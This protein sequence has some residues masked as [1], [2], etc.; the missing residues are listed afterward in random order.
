MAPDPNARFRLTVI[1]WLALI[2]LLISK[3]AFTQ[4]VNGGFGGTGVFPVSCSNN[5]QRWFGAEIDI[6]SS[7]NRLVR[8]Y[9]TGAS[10]GPYN[11]GL[12]IYNPPTV[13][14]GPRADDLDGVAIRRV[15]S[16]LYLVTIGPFTGSSGPHANWCMGTFGIGTGAQF[17]W[18]AYVADSSGNLLNNGNPYTFRGSYNTHGDN[19]DVLEWYASPAAGVDPLA[20]LPNQLQPDNDNGSGDSTYIFRVQYANGRTS[21]LNL[22]PRWGWTYGTLGGDDRT[23]LIV[24]DRLPKAAPTDADAGATRRIT[25]HGLI[26]GDYPWLYGRTDDAWIEQVGDYTAEKPRVGVLDDYHLRTGAEVL[27]F[28][29][30]N[31]QRPHFMLREDPED[32][33]FRDTY[34]VRY[35]YVIQP[36]DFMNFLDNLFQF[37]YDPPGPDEQDTVTTSIYGTPVSNGYVSL[38][39]G[40]HTYEFAATDDFFPPRGVAY[41][42]I[43]WPGNQTRVEYW[44]PYPET[45]YWARVYGTG[46]IS[47]EREPRYTRVIRPFGYPY[48]S[49]DPDQYPNVNP[50]LSGFPY[51]NPADR[52]GAPYMFPEGGIAP[53]YRFMRTYQRVGGEPR[54]VPNIMYELFNDSSKQYELYPVISPF[55]SVAPQGGP[56]GPAFGADPSRP[57]QPTH[58]TNDD[59]IR[60]NY[61][62]IFEQNPNDSYTDFRGGKWTRS[63]TYTFLVNY[64]RRPSRSPTFIRC[65]IRKNLRGSAPGNWVGFTMNQ[66][67][68]SDT[69]YSNGAV[70]Y[71]QVSADQLPGGGGPGDYNYYF[72]ASDGS[73]T[74]I[75]PN[76][77]PA[78]TD[79][80]TRSTHLEYDPLLPA[81]NR[82]VDAGVSVSSAGDNDYYWFRVNDPPVLSDA[83]VLP[84]SDR[85]GSNFVYYVT[86]TDRDGE[87]LNPAAR[88]DEPFEATIHIDLF[89]DPQGTNEVAGISTGSLTYTTE[90]GAGYPAGTLVDANRPFYIR[91]E[92]AA[93]PA[94]RGLTYR[95]TSNDTTTIHATPV[96]PATGL[97]AD[98][99]NVGDTFEI[100]QWFDATMERVTPSD[101]DATDGIRYIL[102]TA[103]LI[104][105][106]PGLH[107]YYFTFRDDWGDWLYPD[108]PNVSVEGERVRYPGSSEFE[109]PEVLGNTAPVLTNYRFTPD[110]PGAG[111]DGT[112]ATGFQFYVTYRDA[113][114]DPPSV[115][116]LGID[117]TQDTPDL[118]LNMMPSDPNDTV[119]TDGVVYETNPVRLTAGK[120]VFRAQTSDGELTYPPRATPSD[121]LLFVGPPDVNGTP[122][123]SAAGPLVAQNTAPVLEFETH[124]A[125]PAATSPG[126]EPDAGTEQDTYTY[127]IIYK[128]ADVFAGVQGNPPLWVRVY[129]DGV[130]QDMTQV[131][132]TD[133]D[134]TD[135]AL[136]E[137]KV[138]GLVAGTAHSYYFRASDGLDTARRPNFPNKY[139]GPRVDQPPGGA[140]SLVVADVPND[141]GGAIQGSFNPSND[142]GGGADDVTEYRVY[143]DTNQNMIN[144][145]LAVTVP[146]AGLGAYSFVHDTAPKATDLWYVVRAY[147]GTNESVNSNVA[148]PVRATDNIPPQAPT[149][150]TVN[151]PGAGSR[152]DLTWTKSGDDPPAGAADV[153]EYRIYRAQQSGGYGAALASVPAGTTTYQDTTATDGVDFFYLI[154]AWDGENLSANSNEVGPVQSTDNSPPVLSDF[155][156]AP[157]ARNVP[158]DTNISF[159]AT[160]T[161]AGVNAAT[162]KFEVTVGGVPVTGTISQAPVPNGFRFTLDPENDF[163]ELDVVSVNIEVSDLAVPVPRT[164]RKSY[165][166]IIAAPPTYTI[167]GTITE[168]DAQ[169]GTK[170]VQGVVV[171][172]GAL[173]GT[174]DANGVYTITGLVNG[175]YEVVP[176]RKGKAF[177][178]ASRNVTVADA[179]VPGVDF[180]AVSGYNI[181]GHVRGPNGPMA[182]VRVSNGLKDAVTN[183]RG[184]YKIPNSPAG[185]YVVRAALPGFVF[186][187]TEQVVVLPGS[188]P[189]GSAVNIDFVGSVETFTISGTVSTAD[190]GVLAGARVTAEDATAAII[191]SG[192]TDTN[193]A[194][195]LR[196]V[197]AGTYTVRVQKSGFTFEP[198]FLEVTVGPNSINNDF[199]AFELFT[200]T[201][202]RGLSFLAVPVDPAN[203]DVVAVLG[204]DRVARWDPTRGGADKYVYAAIDPTNEILNLAPGRGFFV[205][206]DRPTDLQVAGRLIRATDP[207]SLALERGFNMAG[208]PYPVNLPWSNLI[209]G[210]TGPVADYGFI[211]EPG[212]RN[213]LLVSDI[214]RLNA[215]R[216]IPRGAGFWIEADEATVVAINGPQMAAV[217]EAE[218]PTAETNERNWVIPVVASSPVA[219]DLSSRAGITT[220]EALQ[221][222]NPP[223]VAGTVDLYFNGPSGKALALD[224]R[225]GATE[226]LEWS[227]AVYT[228]L[229][230]TPI[231]VSLP[232][233][234]AV[235]KEM[236][237]TLVDVAANKRMSARAATGYTYNS[238]QGGERQFRLLVEPDR[239]GNLTVDLAAMP[240]GRGVELTYTLAKSAVVTIRV[241]NMAGR[242]V[243]TV[244]HGKDVAAGTNTTIWNLQNEQGLRVPSGTYLV[245]LEAVAEDGQQ[246]QAMRPVMVRR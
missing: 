47:W 168:S 153:T 131:D 201:F 206:F 30:G 62:N 200:Q 179:D 152:L 13:M 185:T 110:A 213:Y 122:T 219:A 29:D 54:L 19:E 49:Q 79:S 103:N 204:T 78:W 67:D 227:F 117:G 76:R 26:T 6:G 128:D 46:Q 223:R 58:Y 33:E 243:A 5:S 65:M 184:L 237:I 182:N 34:G 145:Q 73:R 124:D 10:G 165:R 140:K 194:F 242:E 222:A 211:L 59:T 159:T 45:Q 61:G 82:Q 126:L 27:L 155:D 191:A 163:N 70:F 41:V 101:N 174:T 192:R 181:E 195:T 2:W 209:I 24:F 132:P 193:G 235:P 105:L 116:R 40:G 177:I 234:T 224:I 125:P 115:I 55:E 94:A 190:G 130:A 18:G 166:F 231:T 167:S 207:F 84:S 66:L 56:A 161:G 244:I 208:N 87:V 119:Y 108:S 129:V 240:T 197:P 7:T 107:R 230:D 173:S 89:G 144:P 53:D 31:I 37:R 232:D 63:T 15:S 156:P 121:P 236:R 151:N 71:F 25:I 141:Q 180:T 112:T 51:F 96:P 183:A 109:G 189:D 148:G 43:G 68:P 241:R 42:Q 226:T 147:D 14:E 83:D 123:D 196:N 142:D 97:G 178:P 215:L 39:P 80:E 146:A 102:S 60:P 4:S 154:R 217:K 205:A 220:G 143:Y 158:K 86:Y 239:G 95:I 212:T 139:A 81:S 72:I 74:T 233:L 175:T 8:V 50:V 16:T 136:F 118:I 199:V 225:A 133:T 52:P 162:R 3:A 169:G 90:L 20:V 64:W 1:T 228:D 150:L 106:G 77:P 238:G 44:H 75:F 22:P 85:Q 99:I 92:D 12:Q 157:G 246:V 170:G 35:K 114:N 91:I 17:E 198:E 57:N 88:G 164:A 28:I 187:P 135:G 36:T 93:N 134:Y 98:P 229:Q 100:L 149:N 120:H 221:A 21:G 11:P 245:V 138:T 104:T 216:N 9:F 214:A 202:P 172:A 113:E 176:A 188:E 171:Y 160:D 203:D 23:Q 69:D 48:D 210:T 32:N 137:Y 218:T 127:H 111:P 38:P 186:Q